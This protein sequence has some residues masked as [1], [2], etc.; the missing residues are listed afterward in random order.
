M[1]YLL[2]SSFVIDLLNEI[3]D[4]SPGP[5]L[6][7]LERD[8]SA[9][10]WISPVTVA[11]VLEGADDP[12]AVKAYL[13]RYGWQGMHRT[14]AERVAHRQRRASHR[15]GENDAWQ[16]AIAETMGASIV[17]HD[18]AAFARLGTGYEDFRRA[19]ARAGPSR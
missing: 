13:G 4:G 2:D 11:E 5:A 10:L 3:A 15:M 17:A 8:S 6:G 14:H 1:K 18:R 16:V 9:R 19:A 12:Q 7:W